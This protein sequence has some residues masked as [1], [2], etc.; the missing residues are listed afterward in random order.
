MGSNTEYIKL[1]MKYESDD[2]PVVYFY[3]VDLD[4]DRLCVRA[5]EVLNNRQVKRIDDLY[6]NVIEITPIPTKKELNSNIWGEG[7]EAF[8]ISKEEFEVVWVCGEY[9]G[10]LFS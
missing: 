6:Y 5:I 7:F 9:K 2:M 3:E 4:N 10:D 8:I 1:F